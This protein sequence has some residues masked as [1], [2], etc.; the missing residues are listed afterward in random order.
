MHI[1]DGRLWSNINQILINS[2]YT[3]WPNWKWRRSRSFIGWLC[4]INKLSSKKEL[5]RKKPAEFVCFGTE[6]EWILNIA[7]RSF[8][9]SFFY[10]FFFL[11][12]LSLSLSASFVFFIFFP[13]QEF[14]IERERKIKRITKTATWRHSQWTTQDILWQSKTHSMLCINLE[15]EYFNQN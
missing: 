8:V 4:V 7:I 13:L 15:Y 2:L 6:R 12:C 14:K 3:H 5:T 10:L 11:L 1:F 9:R